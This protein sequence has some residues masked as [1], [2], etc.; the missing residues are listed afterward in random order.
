[1]GIAVEATMPAHATVRGT[2]AGLRRAVTAVVDNAVRHA[3]RRVGATI[4]ATPTL[5]VVEIADDGPGIDAAVLPR[6]FERFAT[7]G[8]HRQDRTRQYGIGLAL[9]SEVIT[10]H[11]GTVT[12]D[13]P[14]DGGAVFRIALPSA[15]TTGSRR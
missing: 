8:A 4:T 11:S 15:P 6:V 1:M 3:A 9:V 13:N 5:V 10:R 7:S 14:P 2:E 12:A